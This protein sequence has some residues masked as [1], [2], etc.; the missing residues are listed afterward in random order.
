[1]PKDGFPTTQQTWIGGRLEH[2][3]RGVDQVNQHV[4][5]VYRKPLEI[6]FRGMPD[7]RQLE[8]EDVVAG[9]FA[10]RLARP[11]FFHDWSQSPLLLRRWLMNAL[12]YDVLELRR[13]R[14]VQGLNEEIVVAKETHDAAE[15]AFVSAIVREAMSRAKD[16]CEKDGLREHWELFVRHYVQER[17]Y[18]RLTEEFGLDERRAAV[19]VRTAAN[20][21]RAAV[22]ELLNR[23]GVSSSD[24]ESE[25]KSLSEL[26]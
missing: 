18:A 21:F 22:I 23:D 24:L 11:N 10:N 20:R 25:I 4:M 8:P 5:D 1:M 3:P 13:V 2:G 12:R 7:A 9:F 17:P 16:S 26:V 15:R 19:M 14:R 6:Y